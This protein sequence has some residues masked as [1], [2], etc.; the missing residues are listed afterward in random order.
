[1]ERTL[2]IHEIYSKHCRFRI[3]IYSFRVNIL[4]KTA[5]VTRILIF[6]KA[7]SWQL[8]VSPKKME[9]KKSNIHPS[10]H[11]HLEKKKSQV[12]K[13]KIQQHILYR[14]GA[15][16][17]TRLRSQT[18]CV[19]KREEKIFSMWWLCQ[20]MMCRFDSKWWSYWFFEHSFF[21]VL[22]KYLFQL[23]Q[24]VATSDSSSF[25][26]NDTHIFYTALIKP[27]YKKKKKKMME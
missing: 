22:S 19:F 8:F 2:Y 7:L 12:E 4:F 14:F 1:M 20:N 13:R 21:L 23:S 25:P 5:L 3:W 11:L 9:E 16:V 6:S 17:T 26:S 18:I 24:S 10:M 27:H 15:P